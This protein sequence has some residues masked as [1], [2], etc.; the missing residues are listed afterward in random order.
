MV[1]ALVGCDWYCLQLSRA[2]LWVVTWPEALT[3][4]HRLFGET[5]FGLLLI[6]FPF[7]R[8]GKDVLK[9]DGDSLGCNLFDCGLGGR[10]SPYIVMMIQTW[11]LV[12]F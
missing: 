4:L 3:S 2:L 9:C 7:V 10:L 6:S 1:I 11:P 12:A 5:T 8:R